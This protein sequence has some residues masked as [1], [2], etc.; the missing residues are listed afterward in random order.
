MALAVCVYCGA[1]TGTNPAYRV[2]AQQF[3]AALA[4]R[5]WSL[6]YGGGNV[7][8]MG[9]VA[10]GALDAGGQVIGV[11]PQ[12]LLDIEVGLRDATELIV[13]ET[14]RE[15]KAIMDARADAFVTLPGGFGTLEELLEVLTLRQLGYHTRP[16]ILINLDGYYTPL[17]RLFAHTVEAGF[18]APG[19]LDLY[20]VVSSVEEAIALL[21]AVVPQAGAAQP[22]ATNG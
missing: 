9:A 19:Q 22:V 4:Q 13:T 12:A 21:A 17:L 8:L 16:I 11:I 15:R 6:I 14:M 10:H 20:Q 2:A 3:G 7:G 18:V 5:G 1:H